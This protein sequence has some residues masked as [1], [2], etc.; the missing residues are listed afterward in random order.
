[1]NSN[2][3]CVIP[4][5]KVLFAATTISVIFSNHPAAFAAKSPQEIAQIA[6]TIAVQINRPTGVP[7]GQANDGSGFIIQREGNTYT[8]LTNDHVLNPSS[9]PKPAIIR[10]GDGEGHQITGAKSLGT[11]INGSND[12]GLLTFS[13]SKQYPVATLAS[14]TQAK[15]GSTIFVFGY[16]VNNALGRIAEARTSAFPKGIIWRSV[17]ASTTDKGGYTMFYTAQTEGGMSGGPV[18]DIDG[19]VIGVHGRS[20]ET[21]DT[22]QDLQAGQTLTVERKSGINAAIPIDTFLALQR[23]TGLSGVNV[24][25]TLSTDKPEQQIN[26]PQSPDAFVAKG[27]SQESN[28]AAAINNYT[29]AI[30][31]DPNYSD[32]YYRRAVARY[33]QGDKQGAITD[34]N[35]AIRLNPN[36]AIAYYNR[37]VA[38]YNLRD[39]QAA[40]A[41]FSQYISFAPNDISA[42]YS[43]GTARRNL[44][45][46]RGMFEDFDQIVRL[47]PS[48][49][50]SYFNRALA[51]AMLLDKKGTIA[52]FTEAIR[53]DPRYT[54]A[55]INRAQVLRRIGNREGAIQDLTIV[56]Q[57]QPD[58]GIAYYTRGLFRRDLGDRQGAFTDLQAAITI[59]QQKGDNR[60][61]QK[62]VEVMQRLQTSNTNV[63]TPVPSA[64]PSFEQPSSEDTTGDFDSSI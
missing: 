23:Q 40:I 42:Y 39:Y 12:L 4:Y 62:A 36:K 33:D 61:Y 25:K 52:D 63:S 9:G 13:S 44:K 17:N 11:Y 16:P 20:D 60:S 50:K 58:N 64:K 22:A 47:D 15:L 28:K 3:V 26:N 37:G 19:R 43:R 5:N 24:D 2:F 48:N 14:S 10:T 55:Y 56:L 54:D 35:E 57:I 34:Y 32:A 27:L 49:S 51:R 1:M 21:T 46:G 41:D 59:F 18:F 29:Q 53:L 45:D 8:V 7:V 31:L 30:R 38:L 6:N